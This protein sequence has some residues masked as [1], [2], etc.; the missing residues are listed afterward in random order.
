MSQAQYKVLYHGSAELFD[1][2]DVSKGRPR[3]D[4]GKG[5]YL[6]V[7]KQ[8]AIKVMRKK[9]SELL[10]RRPGRRRLRHCIRRGS[11]CSGLCSSRRLF[12]VW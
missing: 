1:M 7:S 6:A 4:F 10:N 3:K 9:Y 5:F 12:R 8:L 11:V 2:I